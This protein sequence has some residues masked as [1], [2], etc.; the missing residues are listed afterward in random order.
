MAATAERLAGLAAMLAVGHGKPP[1]IDSTG[2]LM[3][4]VRCSSSLEAGCP[5]RSGMMPRTTKGGP[6]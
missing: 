5:L 4:R 2:H 6:T 3:S 1:A